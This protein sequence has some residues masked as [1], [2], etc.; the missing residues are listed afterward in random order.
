MSGAKILPFASG[1]PVA[2]V[3]P[4]VV[5][6]RE[7]PPRLR[8]RDE[9]TLRQQLLPLTIVSYQYG[10]VQLMRRDSPILRTLAATQ[11]ER[12]WRMIRRAEPRVASSILALNTLMMSYGWE[13]SPEERRKSRRPAKTLADFGQTAIGAIHCLPAVIEAFTI[14]LYDGWQPYQLIWA[15]DAVRFRGRSLWGLTHVLAKHQEHF[16]FTPSWELV[17]RDPSNWSAAPVVF[18][19]PRDRI[20]WL[21]GRW[22]STDS[23]YGQADLEVIWLAHH[24]KQKFLEW[25]QRAARS[26]ANGIPIFKDKTPA[27][28]QVPIAGEIDQGAGREAMLEILAEAKELLRIYDQTGVMVCRGGMDLELLTNKTAL[29]GWKGALDYLDSQIQIYIEGQHLTSEVK[30]SGSRALGDTHQLTKI[31]YARRNAAV[32]EDTFDRLLRVLCEQNFP[33]VDPDDLPHFRLGIHE[34]LEVDKVQ[35]AY[36]MGARLDADRIAKKWHLPLAA[37]DADPAT[38]WQKGASAA[39]PAAANTPTSDGGA[40]S[41]LGRAQPEDGTGVAPLD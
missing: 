9:A 20:A 24:V 23:P 29:D 1:Y 38:V 26:N 4:L 15:T 17:Y 16:F 3:V 34:V 2:P 19:E 41:D 13:I 18:S 10:N 37:L 27:P 11:D 30:E 33:S 14:P 7:P 25:Y 12:E 35:A 21:V 32:V 40:I 39:P 22:G 6:D 28:M 31:A 36:G 5:D 8:P